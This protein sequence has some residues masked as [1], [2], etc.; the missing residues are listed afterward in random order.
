MALAMLATGWANPSIAADPN[1]VI[2]T[3]TQSGESGFDCQMESD[4]VTGT[5]CDSLFDSLL[6]YD[7]LARPI[8][9]Q[10]RTAEAL[11]EISADGKIW[12]LKLRPGIFFTAHP[13]FKDKKRELVASDY[14]YSI[15]RLLDPAVRSKWQF[16]VEG[17][18]VGGDG[19][20]NEARRSGRFDYDRPIA[21]LEARDGE[22]NDR[23]AGLGQEQR[24][25]RGPNGVQK[26]PARHR[27]DAGGRRGGRC[28]FSCS[29][30]RGS[31]PPP[32]EF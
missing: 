5:L 28:F 18:L 9:L 11:P 15:K 13:A 7:H 23:A 27:R 30:H 24:H 8:K 32:P 26:F 20:V 10:P 14:V 4:E 17:K 19:L 16:L 25:R 1:K 2:R 6:Q 3:A 22:P 31:S 29:R 21:G 12:T